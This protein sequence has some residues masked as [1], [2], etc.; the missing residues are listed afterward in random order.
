MG[1]P[2]EHFQ[3]P[4]LEI[5]WWAPRLLALEILGVGPTYHA[6][7]ILG[8]DPYTLPLEINRWVL[9]HWPWKYSGGVH[10]CCLGNTY[11]GPTFSTIGK[12]QD[13]VQVQKYF[14]APFFQE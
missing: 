10:L 13:S 1:V 4:P 2:L 12:T 3:M 6:L 8:W 9:V 11:V 14:Q 7:E 5:N